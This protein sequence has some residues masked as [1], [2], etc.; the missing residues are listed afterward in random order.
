HPAVPTPVGSAPAQRG[1]SILV[2]DDNDDAADTLAAAL[3]LAGY[4]TRAVYDAAE[5]LRVVDTFRPFAAILDIGLP[6]MTGYELAEQLRA[7]EST[8]TTRLVALSGYTQELALRRSG[9][10]SREVFDAYVVK[11]ASVNEILQILNQF[12]TLTP[13]S[14][15]TSTL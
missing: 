6:G 13:V 3:Q 1:R 10:H 5:A 15:R 4:E 12:A 9:K 7:R 11:P 8:A 2:V 14:P